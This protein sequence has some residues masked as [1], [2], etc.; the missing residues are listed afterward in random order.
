MPRHTPLTDSEIAELR[1]ICSQS[2]LRVV[3]D[4]TAERLHTYV[5]H[6]IVDLLAVR[7]ELRSSQQRA[8]AEVER[9]RDVLGRATPHLERR[10]ADAEF[11]AL[12]AEIEDALARRP[13]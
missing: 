8:R 12:L 2:T 4:E 11:Q 13:F 7:M 6:L 5:S 9:L 1:A 3:S 10:R